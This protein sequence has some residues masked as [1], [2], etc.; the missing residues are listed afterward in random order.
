MAVVCIYNGYT[1]PFIYGPYTFHQTAT[2]A[3]LSF[4][5]IIKE[6]S[7]A[8]LLSAEAALLAATKEI[9]KDFSMSFNGTSEFSL[10]NN[11]KGF[12]ARVLVKKL[13]TVEYCTE[14]TRPFN[15]TIQY[16]LPYLQDA[17]KIEASWTLTKSESRQSTFIFHALYSANDATPPIPAT[18]VAKNDFPTWC[19]SVINTFKDTGEIFERI[20]D[21]LKTDLHD[22]RATCYATYKQVLYEYSTVSNFITD[23]KTFYSLSVVPQTYKSV[24][25][26][27]IYSMPL[28]A[29][30]LGF[31]GFV[32]KSKSKDL[33]VDLYRDYIKQQMILDAQSI[34]TIN[35]FGT[36]NLILENSSVNFNPSTYY[37]SG[38]MTLIAFQGKI[39]QNNNKIV[40]YHETISINSSENWVRK[41]MWDGEHFTYHSFSAGAT[42]TLIRS[43]RMS[44]LVFADSIPLLPDTIFAPNHTGK[45]V[46]EDTRVSR[47]EEYLG[48]TLD[49]SDILGSIVSVFHAEFSQTYTFMDVENSVFTTI[50]VVP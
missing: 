42:S 35:D 23:G 15:I 22:R 36:Q 9:K 30:R 7:S 16:L 21:N 4:N 17:G 47:G 29:I 33:C 27:S 25:T 5:C 11:N 14:T 10:G 45:W 49:P 19:A 12:V 37:L 46:L 31:S 40:S 44:S 41:K 8:N 39:D 32:D 6:D 24:C 20:T 2:D 34:L 1:F 18:T 28:I 26:P 43:V 13:E 38:N 3:S 48:L 50:K